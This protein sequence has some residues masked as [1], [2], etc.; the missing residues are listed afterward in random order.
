[1]TAS[2]KVGIRN[3]L[4]WIEASSYFSTEECRKLKFQ[5]WTRVEASIILI[6]LKELG[7]RTTSTER[8]S[9]ALLIKNLLK[10]DPN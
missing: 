3:A 6:N 7:A 1:M 10:N 5:M 8:E 9:A 4:S 2:Q